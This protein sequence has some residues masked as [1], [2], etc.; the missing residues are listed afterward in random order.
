MSNSLER[1]PVVRQVQKGR[2]FWSSARGCALQKA[3]RACLGPVS[4]RWFGHH[5]LELGLGAQLANICSVQH[6]MYWV[7]CAELA[8]TAESLVCHPDT[9]PLPDGCLDLVLIHHLLE[10]TAEPHRVLQ[11]ATRVLADD[12]NLIIFGWSPLSPLALAKRLPKRRSELSSQERW[13]APKQ[14]AEW[15]A[16]VDFDVQRVDYCGF[17]LPSRRES[18]SSLEAFGR[19]HNL[20]FGECYMIHARRRSLLILPNRNK[21]VFGKPLVGRALNGSAGLSKQLEQTTNDRN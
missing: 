10:V 16:F 7:P 17:R 14:L 15:L 18:N 13:R 6:L 1:Q 21:L 9:L 2:E 3:E 11:E 5:G 20:P 8:E 12:G 4:D 19:R